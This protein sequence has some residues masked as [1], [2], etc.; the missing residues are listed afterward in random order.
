LFSL[1]LFN[2]Y[3]HKIISLLVLGIN[4]IR[5]IRK[6]LNF[7]WGWIYNTICASSLWK[8]KSIYSLGIYKILC[9][10]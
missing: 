1:I 6:F 2:L 5:S 8:K 3:L 9:I 4:D 7:L 10:Y